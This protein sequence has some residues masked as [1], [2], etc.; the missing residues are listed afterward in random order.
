MPLT[1]AILTP[2]QVHRAASACRNNPM[3]R[4]H[5][6]GKYPSAGNPVHQRSAKGSAVRQSAPF[7]RHSSRKHHA[8]GNEAV[9]HPCPQG[10]CTRREHARPT[11]HPVGQMLPTGPRHG[12]PEKHARRI[13]LTRTLIHRAVPAF[14]R[15]FVPGTAHHAKRTCQKLGLPTAQFPPAGAALS[16]RYAGSVHPQDKSPPY[17]AVHIVDAPAGNTPLPQRTP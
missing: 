12:A 9:L 14:R 13:S 5:A 16:V 1:D 4:H 2:E 3:P 10:G 15:S 17:N 7:P 8:P 6:P 11:T